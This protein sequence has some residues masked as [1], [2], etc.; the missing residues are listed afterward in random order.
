LIFHGNGG[1][2]FTDVYNMPVWA[3]KFYIGKIVEFRQEE[4]KAYDKE[5][6]KAKSRR[7]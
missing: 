1:F 6:V 4:K 7:R 2:N 3:R 5:S